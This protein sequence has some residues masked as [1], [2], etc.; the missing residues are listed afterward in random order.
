MFVSYRCCLEQLQSFKHLLP[1][2]G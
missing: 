1:K 2:V